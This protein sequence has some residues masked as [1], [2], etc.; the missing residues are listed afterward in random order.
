MTRKQ[1]E[2]LAVDALRKEA[3]KCGQLVDH[4]SEGDKGISWDGFIEVYEPTTVGDPRKEQY[5]GDIKVQ[6]KGTEVEP[7]NDF[8]EGHLKKSVEISHIR[9]Y[10]K[11]L[12][13]TLYFVVQ[14]KKTGESKIFFH[15]FLPV[16]IERALGKAGKKKSIT[17][18]FR[19][20][21][22]FE[23]S[24]YNMCLTF[25]SDRKIQVGKRIF[26]VN[27]TQEILGLERPKHITML[28]NLDAEGTLKF[29]PLHSNA[30]GKHRIYFKN[31]DSL[32][33]AEVSDIAI[34]PQIPLTVLSDGSEMYNDARYAWTTSGKNIVFG[35][36]I[37]LTNNGIE[38]D[39]RGSVKEAKVDIDFLLNIM[40][41]NL[42]IK[43]GNKQLIFAERVQLDENF[44]KKLLEQR[45]WLEKVIGVL[46]RFHVPLEVDLNMIL[47][48]KNSALN[49]LIGES[50]GVKVENNFYFTQIEDREI[51]FFVK[52]NDD[53]SLEVFNP[54]SNEINSVE[55][56]YSV[57]GEK[58]PHSVCWFLFESEKVFDCWNFDSEAALDD[59]R[60]FPINEEVAR[61]I[62][63]RGLALLRHFDA[64]PNREDVLA[65]AEG[66]F[67]LLKS[68]ENSVINTINYYQ[69]IIR[70]RELNLDEKE[71]ISALPEEN[72]MARVCKSVLLRNQYD[73]EK[74]YDQLTSEE[75]ETFA[76]W[77]IAAIY[78]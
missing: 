3:H 30:T 66:L 64:N 20:F 44:L 2:S 16:E 52:T 60:R 10:K 41:K 46:E 38:Y 12:R 31:G 71:E 58:C 42:E 22:P 24:F 26:L 37:T 18:A 59:I 47:E 9:N 4:F 68:E 75:R 23:F 32:A 70:Q 39:A 73:F 77:P 28:A 33:I 25:L 40:D 57:A 69:S 29:S 50:Q 62:A 13:G 53:G 48:Q 5:I 8:A 1:I 74:Y 54:F 34:S 67:Y 51:V 45:S 63:E 72:I 76:S 55:F 6:I 21:N 61:L 7:H 19:E 27:N 49:F 11:E 15:V 36:K 78:K 65:L 17:I 14:V 43:H 56:A 35:N